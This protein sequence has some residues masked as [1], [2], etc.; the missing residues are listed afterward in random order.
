MHY[1]GLPWW[2][3]DKEFCLTMQETHVQVRSLIWED[4]TC[5][6]ATKTMPQLLSLC[7]RAQEPNYWA[8]GHYD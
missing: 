7:S 6:R 3:S 1:D 5:H 2:L 8:L 4:P